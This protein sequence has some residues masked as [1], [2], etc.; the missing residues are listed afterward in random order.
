MNC[1]TKE[2]TLSLGDPPLLEQA[3][4]KSAKPRVSPEE[5]HSLIPQGFS[6]QP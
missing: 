5:K 1:V 4:S 2:G 6:S 3:V